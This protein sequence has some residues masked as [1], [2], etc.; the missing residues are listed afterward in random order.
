[1]SIRLLGGLHVDLDGMPVTDFKSDKA[2]ALLSFLAVEADRP[3]PRDSLA[4]LLWPEVSNQA[5]R[6]NLRSTLA[7]LRKVI[8]DS[9]ASPP[10]LLINRETV[11]FNR[12]SDHWLDVSA[13]MYPPVE[14]EIDS[15]QLEQF[16]SAIALY[17]GPFLNGFSVSDSTPF[18]EWALLKREQINRRVREVLFRLATF[19]E[20]YGKFDQA[21]MY[22]RK[23]VELEPWNEEAHQQLMRLLAMSG[24][25]SAALVQ[26]EAC[27]RLLEKELGVEPSQETTHLYA[28]IRDGAFV[29]VATALGDMPA[30]GAPPYKGLHY[31]DEQDAELFFGRELLT[32]RLVSH[33]GLMHTTTLMTDG[34][35]TGRFLAV[36]GASGSG[37]SSLVRAGLIPAIKRGQKLA[38]D[39]TPP[40]G[41]TAWQVSILTPT[42]HPLQSMAL[43][44]TQEEQSLTA[45]LTL[46]DDFQRD[47]RCLHLF[48]SRSVLASGRRRLLLIVD[49]FEELFTLCKDEAERVAFVDNL[50]AAM[51]VEGPTLVV[52]VLRADFYAHCARYPQLRQ[53]L[54]ERQEFIGP[55]DQQELTKAIEEP[56]RHGGWEFEPGLV[57]LILRDASDEPGMLPL[58][59]H[60]L[61]ET[62]ERRKGRLLTLQGYAETGGVRGAIARTADAVFTRLSPEQQGIT[63]WIFLRLTEPGEGTP[64]S[65]RRATLGELVS[66]AGE[67]GPVAEVL[68]ILA[69]ARLITLSTDAAEV[70]HEA[71]IQEWPALREWIDQDRESLRL[72]RHLTEAALAWEKLDRDSGELYRGAR[73]AQAL[74]WSEQPENAGALNK[75]EQ[76]FLSASH[77]L[78]EQEAAAHEFQRQREL[79]SAQALAQAE[80]QR[81]QEQAQASRRLTRLTAFLAVALVF[82]VI[83]LGVAYLFAGRN[84]SLAEQNAASASFAQTQQAEA[85]FASTQAVAAALGRATQQRLA[86]K[87]ADNK[88]TA[89]ANALSQRDLADRQAHLAHARELALAANLN[90]A[91]DPELSILLAIQAVSEIGEVGVDVPAE[92]QQALHLAV[93]SSRARLTIP[94]HTGEVYALAFSPDGSFLASAGE[95]KLV[96]LWDSKSGTLHMELSGHTAPVLDVAFNPDGTRIATSSED[97]SVKIWETSSGKLLRTLDSLAVITEAV[98]FSPDGIWLATTGVDGSVMLWAADSGQERLKLTAHTD[99][100]SDVSFSPDGAKLASA[101]EDGTAIVWDIQSRR[102]L[103]AIDL[104]Q[105]I[106]SIDYSPDGKRLV[107]GD[108]SGMAHVWDATT[109]QEVQAL[110]GHN[111][112]I[113][114]ALFSPDG[115]YLATASQDGVT[116]I[117]DASS[118]A[119]LYSLGTNAGAVNDAAFSTECVAPPGSP[120]EWCGSP[121][122]TAYRDGTVKIWDVTPEANNELLVLPGFDG[123]YLEPGRL[124]TSLFSGS[125][126][127]GQ[128]WDVTS[129]PAGELLSSINFSGFPAPVATGCLSPD[130][131][132]MVTVTEDGT[133]QLW[134]TSTGRM[135]NSFAL[136]GHT[137]TINE[138]DLSPDHR[139]LATASDDGTARVWDTTSGEELLVLA[140]HLE[141]VWAVAFSPDGSQLATAGTDHKVRLWDASTGEM[142]RTLS[143][144]TLP[145]NVVAFSPDGRVLASAGMDSKV[146]VWELSSGNSLGTLEG[147]TA[148]VI[149][150]AFSPD[151]G[152]LVTGS[153]DG[154]VKVWDLS[155]GI[156]SGTLLLSLPVTGWPVYSHF[157]PDGRYL[158]VG[159]F[160]DQLV[161]VYV[162]D[163]QEL[164]ELARSR[165]TRDLTRQECQQYLHVEACP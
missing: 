121:L 34:A 91:L 53:A 97:Q 12:A 125:E 26:Y 109:G 126:M 3:H 95:D 68:K 159:V 157:S 11:Q 107:T 94:A 67:A 23:L 40:E 63:R 120:A 29:P 143:G 103:L 147:H 165:V 84:A 164:V 50:L 122:A 32:A 129:Q 130:K 28:A 127:V 151:G 75:L 39:T 88:A 78:A 110:A 128:T 161:R 101:S 140:G 80:A 116:K 48:A 131:S 60:A 153:Y 36:V 21:E 134:D 30:P 100:V 46:M 37:K 42:A 2:R 5:A 17:K 15:A 137:A 59:S 82:V 98:Q 146:R 114:E 104:E 86:E 71:L 90:L 156:G 112:M 47:K 7:N 108:H 74:E 31:F 93:L 33:L 106:Y 155:S 45:A 8:N 87:E 6:T 152:R 99:A 57:E 25:R 92:V 136:P 124:Y 141:Y 10:H 96:R 138:V 64:D 55:M 132:H 163:I 72:H 65:R 81:A 54:C 77:A 160:P 20:Q 35:S 73:L 41:C 76:A 44:L 123:Q 162:L 85:Q 119:E 150:A 51:A 1:M 66:A 27:C 14:T 117:W 111:I 115:L 22:T 61:L 13:C 49:Q 16:E 18:E 19:Y 69:D 38:D 83:L 142:L 133:A 102:Q 79:E 105:P 158:S 62:W 154:A 9:Q 145:I 24:K 144:H 58:L 118:G 4:W 149:G 148:S 89:E 56:A 52:I 43:S 70:A 139:W 135:V 113:R